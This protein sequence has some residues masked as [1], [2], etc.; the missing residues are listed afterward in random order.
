MNYLID[1]HNLIGK[2][3]DIKLSDPDDEAKLIL[4]LITWAAVGKNRRVVVVFDGGTHG[5]NWS[6]FKSDRVRA[7]FVPRGKTADAWL[8]N[9][10]RNEVK[11]N[12]REFHVV[13]SD[14][15]I[16]KQAENRRIAHSTSDVFAEALADERKNLS[17]IAHEKKDPAERPLLREHEVDAWMHLFGGEQQ[18][19]LKPYKPRLRAQTEPEKKKEPE[20]SDA[21]AE[22]GLLSPKEVA[23]WLDLFGGEPEV[24]R[25]PDASRRSKSVANPAARQMG[26]H[27]RNPNTPKADPKSPLSQD[28]LDLWHALFGEG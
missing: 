25:V 24:V 19:E 16:I 26:K 6:S 23:E 1:G 8:I 13:S 14:L 3:E 12:V 5:T 11:K 7:V 27:K 22:K 28:D 9:F 17:E 20:L 15:Q 4:R 10:M 18:I 21:P 2:I